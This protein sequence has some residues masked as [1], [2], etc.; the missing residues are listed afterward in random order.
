MERKESAH[1]LQLIKFGCLK[2]KGHFSTLFMGAFAMV[3]PLILVLLVP[4]M[5]S[6]LI[7]DYLI[8]TIGL[9]IFTIILGPLQVG[10]IKFYNDTLDAKQPK[11]SVIYSQLKPSI[12][13]LK[14]IYASGLL[15][16]M[17]IIGG[18]LWILPAGFAISFYSMVLF[19]MERFKYK[20]FSE[21]FNDC[22]R[23]MLGNRLAMFSYKLIFY[24]VYFL[25]FCVALLLMLLISKLTYESLLIAWVVAVCS[26]IIYIFL[27]TMITVYY[28]SCNQVFFEDCL[29]YHD[30]K[31]EE[32][33][34]EH[35]KRQ[36]RLEA[37]KS[38]ATEDKTT[39]TE[40]KTAETKDSDKNTEQKL[41]EKDENKKSTKKASKGEKKTAKAKTSKS[42]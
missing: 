16:I 26:M 17:Y 39:V 28:H 1:G 22:S 23:K 8:F 7:G 18:V 31:Q 4:L 19:F 36:Q 24:F 37:E 27:Y 38:A 11:I 33:K 14:T 20:R 32:K 41:E 34:I 3:T 25:L 40:E 42:K 15:L 21:A 6:M 5:M 30:R 9:I 10:Y 13:T 29:M 2:L 12:F 35:L